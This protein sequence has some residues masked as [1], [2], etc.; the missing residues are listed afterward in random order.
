MCCVR[1]GTTYAQVR[2]RTFHEPNLILIWTDRN[3]TR[4]H[5]LNRTSNLILVWT[6]QNIA[7]VRLLIQTPNLI[8][9][10]LFSLNQISSNRQRF[11]GKVQIPCKIRCNNIRFGTWSAQV[12]SLNQTRSNAEISGWAKKEERLIHSK[13]KHPFLADFDAQLFMYL[14]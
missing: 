2:L 11:S 14:I 4:V 7:R 5:L 8:R 12:R 9:R 13:F 6:Q 1:N 3:F 10:T